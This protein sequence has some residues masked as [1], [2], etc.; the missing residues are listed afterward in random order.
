MKIET[1]GMTLQDGQWVISTEPNDT[2][3]QEI[4]VEWILAGLPKWNRE[5]KEWE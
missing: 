3:T 5:T 1:N 4:T 2:N